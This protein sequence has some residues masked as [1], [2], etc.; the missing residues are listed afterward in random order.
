MEVLPVDIDLLF[1][2][3]YHFYHSSK[4]KQEFTDLWISLF[5]SEPGF[6]LKNCTTRWLSLLYCVNRYISQYDGLLSLCHVVMKSVR[7]RVL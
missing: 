6:F 7:F 5:T 2:I 4:R 3:Y 1:D